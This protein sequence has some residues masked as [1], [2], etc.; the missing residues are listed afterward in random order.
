MLKVQILV[1]V[2]LERQLHKAR[3]IP[4]NNNK[5]CEGG[6]LMKKKLVSLITV[7]CMLGTCLGMAMPVFA[8]EPGSGGGVPQEDVIIDIYKNDFQT[9][10]G[11]DRINGTATVVDDTVAQ[12]LNNDAQNKALKIE[13]VV[14]SSYTPLHIN[15]S[16]VNGWASTPAKY[17]NY[18]AVNGK[19]II[20]EVDFYLTQS[21]VDVL[22]APEGQYGAV[23]IMLKFAPNLSVGNGGNLNDFEKNALG[24]FKRYGTNQVVYGRANSAGNSYGYEIEPERW[25]N[26]KAVLDLE[27]WTYSIYI[28][29]NPVKLLANEYAVN[30]SVDESST[31]P[32]GNRNVES[33]SMYGIAVAY[34]KSSSNNA[35]SRTTLTADHN[36]V[37]YVDN[38]H[39]YQVASPVGV[40]SVSA[41]YRGTTTEIAVNFNTS[42]AE[43]ELE[44]LAILKEDG[45]K[46]SNTAITEVRL[47]QNGH[48]AYLTV[49]T[50]S[51]GVERGGKYTLTL[52][53]GFRDIH[54]QYLTAQVSMPFE[55]NKSASIYVDERETNIIAGPNA[56]GVTVSVNLKNA[57]DSA[58][59]MVILAAY[60]GNKVL[61]GADIQHVTVANVTDDPDGET[62]ELTINANLTD[63]TEIKLFVWN[64]NLS[65]YQG[66]E[67][68]WLKNN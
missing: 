56:S 44:K 20:W 26:Y 19:Q 62:V 40:T 45:S 34:N 53:A 10:D 27:T 46:L 11:I 30:R 37:V 29:D 6:L 31:I 60:A 9:I 8:G 55:I 64:N 48:T 3:F 63:A 58:G 15:L 18:N 2:W 52:P 42:V 4:R 32:E 41:E 13:K 38:I 21:A 12:E 5:L 35:G 68:I 7:L 57:S 28:N 50:G 25:Y 49:Q 51:S 66:S 22:S 17:S 67:L 39:Y 65:P 33:L 43:G 24:F 1:E 54:G 23:N 36:P 16:P 14:R 47:A 59:A 61:L